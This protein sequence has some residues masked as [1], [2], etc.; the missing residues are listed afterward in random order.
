ME[1][2]KQEKDRSDLQAQMET[3]WSS[4]ANELTSKVSRIDEL[5]GEKHWLSVGTYKESLIKSLL[6]NKIPKKHEVS[7]GFVLSGEMKEK[8]INKRVS[9]QL[10]LVIW[11]SSEHSPI[12]RVD[13]FV[14]IPPESCKAVI[15]VKGKLTHEE[16]K[17]G[18]QNLD[19]VATFG[20][21]LGHDNSPFLSL[22]AFDADDKIKFPN[23][24]FSA[25]W[26][27]YRY[28]TQDIFKKR[29][30]YIGSDI[31][32]RRPWINQIVILGKGVISLMQWYINEKRVPVYVAIKTVTEEQNDSYAFME[33]ELIASL[34][35]GYQINLYPHLAPGASSLTPQANNSCEVKDF[36]PITIGDEK[37]NSIVRVKESEIES[38]RKKRFK[39]RKT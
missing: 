12:F 15:E 37:I 22:F 34:R 16:L 24:L 1:K 35:V 39:P 30:G 7:T 26:K 9:K 18:I 33:R 32:W 8:Q 38:W 10:D 36:F 2:D 5:I 17:S 25:L 14:I 29:S 3:L 28:D 31:S 21:L 13:D 20:N 11:D 19:S 23:T 4:Y 27:H 6:K